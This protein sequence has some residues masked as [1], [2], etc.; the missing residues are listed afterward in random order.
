MLFLP[1]VFKD[2]P[3]V[4]VVGFA[5]TLDGEVCLEPAVVDLLFI[6]DANPIRC[7]LFDVQLGRRGCGNRGCQ[8]Q[9]QAEQEGGE[10]RGGAPHMH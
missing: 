1:G 5:V 6:Y 9:E 8:C 3:L 4:I 10:K 7:Q 2:R